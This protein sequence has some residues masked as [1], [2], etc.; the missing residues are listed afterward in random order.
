MFVEKEPI[1]KHAGLAR[2]PRTSGSG[3]A[4]SAAN[5]INQV[6]NDTERK[7]YVYTHKYVCICK[8][9]YIIHV[10]IFVYIYIDNVYMYMIIRIY[11]CL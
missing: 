3:P 8:Y 11:I 2:S 9:T 6:K 5:H 7:F 4:C 1:L 10:S